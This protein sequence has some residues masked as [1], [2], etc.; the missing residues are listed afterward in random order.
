M[1]RPVRKKLVNGSIMHVFIQSH[2]V[3]QDNGS[4]DDDDLFASSM[5]D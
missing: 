3:Q 5:R 1:D 2:K 4:D